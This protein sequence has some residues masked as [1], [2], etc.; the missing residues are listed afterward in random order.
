MASKANYKSNFGERFK[1]LSSKQMLQRFPVALAQVKASNSSKVLLRV[2]RQIIYSFY[3]TREITN[4][5]K[6]I[7][8]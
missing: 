6:Y 1:I 4:T 8:I 3:W 5:K 2:M 7:T